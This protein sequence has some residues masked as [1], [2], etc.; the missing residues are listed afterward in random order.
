MLRGKLWILFF[1]VGSLFGA[2]HYAKVEPVNRF[3]LKSS[4]AG[5]ITFADKSAEGKLI[6]D[7]V[8]VQIDDKM[9]KKELENARATK[10]ITKESIEL[11]REILPTLQENYDRQRGYFK[12]LSRLST[13]SRNQKDLAFSAMS[14]SKNILISTKEKLLNLKK[15]LHDIDY[16]I[17]LLE[18]RI[19]KKSFRLENLY[20]YKLMVNRGDYASFGL[21]IAIVDDL[22]SAKITIFLSEDE[23]K[24]VENSS[25]WINGKKSDLK[26]SKIW[27]EADEKFISSYR[28]EIILPPKYRFSSLVKV[29]I[30]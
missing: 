7:R 3:T 26:F 30:R 29:E 27:R 21:P 6:K 16:K 11:T 17:E 22:S 23:L 28:A 1:I 24:N 18:D 15:Q 20:L 8:I 2:E 9:D 5:L 10:R 25:I 13:A 12:R 19:S 4:V 14:S